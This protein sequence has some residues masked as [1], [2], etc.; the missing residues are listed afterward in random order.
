MEAAWRLCTAEYSSILLLGGGMGAAVC[1]RGVQLRAD[2]V[3]AAWGRRGA[4][5]RAAPEVTVEGCTYCTNQCTLYV[6]VF[7]LVNDF[8]YLSRCLIIIM[9][10]WKH[11]F[12]FL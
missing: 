2:C 3:W 12:A 4:C 6:L 10:V 11:M 1:A 8:W 5:V 7:V 9:S